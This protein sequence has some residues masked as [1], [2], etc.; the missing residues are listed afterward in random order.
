MR[1]LLILFSG[2]LVTILGENALGDDSIFRNF[3]DDARRHF[4]SSSFAK[5]ANGDLSFDLDW[6]TVGMSGKLSGGTIIKKELWANDFANSINWD[7]TDK[8]S[9]LYEASKQ[10]PHGPIYRCNIEFVKG[11]STFRY[12]FERSPI[13]SL[14]DIAKDSHGTYPLFAYRRYFTEELIDASEK[15]DLRIGHQALIEVLLLK[16]ANV[17]EHHMEFYALND[18]IGDF[19]NGGLN[20]Y[21]SRSISW[22]SARYERTKLYPRVDKALTKLGRED[23]KDMFEEAIALFAHYNEPVEAAR[24][25]MNIPALPKQEESDIGSRFWEIIYEIEE[26]TEA[27]MKANKSKFA[28]H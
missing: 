11:H 23:A 6:G 28:Y 27:Y 16:G 17:P 22:D 25:Q 8:L 10:H 4:Q 26:Q 20:Q 1:L 2:F 14:S 24:K 15:G 12:Y 18:F 13:Q 3:E 19:L 5:K 7:A 9:N 21:F